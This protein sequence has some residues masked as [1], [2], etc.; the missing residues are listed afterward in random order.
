[1]ALPLSGGTSLIL[2]RDNSISFA[3]LI[4]SHKRSEHLGQAAID[5][6]NVNMAKHIKKALN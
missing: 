4:N 3:P 5:S 1:V 6:I 2:A